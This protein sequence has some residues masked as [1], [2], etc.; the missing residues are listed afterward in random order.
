MFKKIAIISL[1]LFL[2]LFS[3]ASDN[4]LMDQYDEWKAEQDNQSVEQKP[5]E[6][7][8]AYSNSADHYSFNLPNGWKE[9]PKSVIDKVMDEIAKQANTKRV[10]YISGFQSE[11]KEYFEYPYILV[12]NHK[13]DTPSFSQIEKTLN[14]GDFQEKVN[15]GT[16]A[17][18]ELLKNSAI[19]KPFIDKE[20][21]IIFMNTQMDVANIGQVK[22]LMAMFIGKNGIA[23]LNFYSKTNE[24][25]KWLPVFNS[26]IDSFKYEDGFAYNPTEAKK[27][28]EPPLFKGVL[29]EGITG[30]IGGGFIM[31]FAAL[32]GI[33]FRKNKKKNN[34]INEYVETKKYCKECGNKIN[35]LD[36]VCD[37]CGKEIINK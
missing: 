28:D 35:A 15:R 2:P 32:L 26:V 23:Q 37:K 9:I 24:Y 1:F 7:I 3:Y 16:S 20:H 34:K 21:N 31:L 25:S 14:S 6:Q 8:L 36:T 12:Q 30:A 22:G 27:N 18:S 17:Y 33:I 13:L 5:S 19:E 11:G 4:R 29:E 10:E